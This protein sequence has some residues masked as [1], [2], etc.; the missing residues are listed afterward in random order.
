MATDY[1]CTL[2]DVNALAVQVPFSASSKPSASLVTTLIASVAARMDA[3]LGNVGYVTP[4]VSGTKSLALL[5]EACA[6]G[7]MGMAQQIRDSGVTTAVNASGRETKN[8]WLQ[9]FD[10][11]LKRLCN[12]QDPFE[13]PD[14]DRTTEQLE[15]QGANV[16]RSSVQSVDDTNWLTPNVTREQ[17]L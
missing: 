15:K 9:M 16:L 6:W 4:I 12:P 2:D 8:I 13:L 3:M 1:Y 5:R 7:A 14:A 11:W 17:V 10:D